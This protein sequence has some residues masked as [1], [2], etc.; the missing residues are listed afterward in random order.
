MGALDA[1]IELGD[2]VLTHQR[3]YRAEPRRETVLDLLALDGKNPRSILFQLG[4]L[5]EVVA[6][7]PDPGDPARRTP[8]TH[9]LLRLRTDLEVATPGELT[10]DRLRGIAAELQALHDLVGQAYF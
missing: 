9:K 1:A 5:A 6:D 10:P 3:R 2:S 8:I 4:V 7:L